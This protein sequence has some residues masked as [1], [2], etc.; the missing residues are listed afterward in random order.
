M[1]ER[2]AHVQRSMLDG[3]FYKVQQIEK[4]TYVFCLL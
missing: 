2:D 4:H 1:A 3:N